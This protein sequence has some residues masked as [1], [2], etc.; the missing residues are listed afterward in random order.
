MVV[1]EEDFLGFIEVMRKREGGF[2][3][4]KDVFEKEKLENITNRKNLCLIVMPT[5]RRPPSE[6]AAIPD[7]PYAEPTVSALA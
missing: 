4:L 6:T 2:F 1:C 5:S 3:L 7:M